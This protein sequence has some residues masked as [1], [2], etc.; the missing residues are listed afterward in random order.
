VTVAQEQATVLAVK[1]AHVASSL[2]PG[3]I[4]HADPDGMYADVKAAGDFLAALSKP[5]RY[6]TAAVRE[7]RSVWRC[8]LA[9][10]VASLDLL[11]D[12]WVKSRRKHER[13]SGA[14]LSTLLD[15]IYAARD[16]APDNYQAAVANGKTLLANVRQAIEKLDQEGATK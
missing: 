11:K 4:E 14:V 8:A 1:L 5:P 15:I 2:T 9:D 6:P 7:S 12:R 13:D 16:P 10:A 3:A